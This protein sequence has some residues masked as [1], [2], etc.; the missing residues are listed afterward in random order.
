MQEI[1]EESGI[2][3]YQL[4]LC[5]DNLE[6]ALMARLME[7]DGSSGWPLHYL[8]ACYSRLSDELRALTTIRNQAEIESI[9]ST[10]IYSKQLTVSYSGLLI[11]MDMFPQVLLLMPSHPNVTLI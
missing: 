4:R 6:R 3:T 9:T 2:P 5:R 1:S 10:L 11:N 8:M 7:A